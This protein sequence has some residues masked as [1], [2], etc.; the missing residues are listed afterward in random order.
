MG[1]ECALY[2]CLQETRIVL[3]NTE[4]LMLFIDPEWSQSVQG[5][6]GVNDEA[7]SFFRPP[8]RLKLIGR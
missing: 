2:W 5:D 3:L 1:T 7:A 6:H 8:E 4:S